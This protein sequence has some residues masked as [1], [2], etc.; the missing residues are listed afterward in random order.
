M[1]KTIAVIA[2]NGRSGR[3]FVDA[4]LKAGYR[5]RAGVRGENSFSPQ[6]NLTVVHCDANVKSDIRQL[7]DGADAVVSLVGHGRKSPPHLQTKTMQ[8]VTQVMHDLG[9]KRLISLT[10]TGVRTPGDTP[11]MA[12]KIGNAIITLIDPNRIADGI[13]H[14]RV[15]EA[16]DLDWTIL[17][18][19]KLGNG[20]STRK[21][22]LS[23][24]G[25]AELLTPRRRVAR[26]IVQLIE[27]GSYIRQLPIII[28]EQ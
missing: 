5:V 18:V 9:M 11:N 23:L 19:L 22:Q 13:E 17:R 15:I 7:L 20:S 28:G 3:A 2:A 6:P 14:A 4:A 25:P 16:S 12:D 26:A 21:V 24:H 27:E 8:I 1:N 10:G